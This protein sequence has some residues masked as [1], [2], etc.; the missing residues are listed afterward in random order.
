[1]ECGLVLGSSGRWLSAKGGMCCNWAGTGDLKGLIELIAHL[2]R[3]GFDILAM[4]MGV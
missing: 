1:M 4:E 2:M 3:S